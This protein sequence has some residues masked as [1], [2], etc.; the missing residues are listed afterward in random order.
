M[1][2]STA[3][4][5]ARQDALRVL[6]DEGDFRDQG[7]LVEALLAL[8]FDTTQSAVSRDLSALGVHKHEGVYRTAA[9]RGTDLDGVSDL[10]VGVRTAPPNLVVLK[11]AVGGAS[12]VALKLDGAGLPEVVGTIAGDD[13][14]FIAVASAADGRR[15]DRLLNSLSSKKDTAS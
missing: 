14:V 2:A 6:L 4:R 13:T 3:D 5:A 12:R 15:L 11:T 1:P 10:L 9:S 7:A 8:G